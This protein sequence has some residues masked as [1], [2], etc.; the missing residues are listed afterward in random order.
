MHLRCK[1]FSDMHPI[2]DTGAFDFPAPATHPVCCRRTAIRN[3]FGL[4][5]RRTRWFVLIC[6]DRD[7]PACT[8]DVS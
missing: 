6:I 2:P 7:A 8:D 5:F 4:R 3:G 1:D